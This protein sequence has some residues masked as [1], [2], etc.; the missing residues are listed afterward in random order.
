MASGADLPVP[1]E[2]SPQ[3]LYD[4]APCGYLTAL[5]DGTVV[6]VNQTFLQW[7]GY[8]R[9]DL[10]G[11]RRFRDLLAVGSLIYYE[12]HVGP[13]L[14]M[15]NE[16]REIALDVTCADGRRLPMLFNAMVS[17]D[18][19]GAPRLIRMT[20]FDATERRRYE[21]ELLRSRQA[22][23]E[24]ER[25]VRVLQKVVAELA[26]APTAT[27]VARTMVDVADAAFGTAQGAGGAPADATLWLVDA[28]RGRLL[29]AAATMSGE[30]GEMRLDA[31]DAPAA[32]ARSGEPYASPSVDRLRADFP[33]SAQ[34][35]VRRGR[36]SS[37][38]LPLVA[39]DV[40]LGVLACAFTEPREFTEDEVQL[41]RMLGQQ[42]GQALDRA[43]LYDEA[44]RREERAVFL[45]ETTR[46]LD[47]THEL[48]PRARR[49]VERLVPEIASWAAVRLAGVPENLAELGAP[50]VGADTVLPLTVRGK[51]SG[52][53]VLRLP[54]DGPPPEF[55]A[56]LAA[57]AALALENARLYEQEHA[58]ARTLQR[59]L[60]AGE[61]PSDLRFAVDT[62]Y[63][64]ST[65][66]LEVGGDWYDAFLIT[67]DK[68]AVV[69]GD[70][71]GRGIHAASTMGQ[72]R[73]AIRALAAAE[74]GPARLVEQLDRFVDQF[75]QARMATVAYAEI[76]LST[77][78]MVYCCAGHMP[79]LLLPRVG[80]PELLWGGRSAPLG[81]RAGRT[82]RSDA[83]VRLPEGVRLL[84]YTDGL[85]ERRDRP[86]D[87]GFA[88]LAAIF[89]DHRD[90]PLTGLTGRLADAM[91]DH[92]QPD[93]V[94]LL[95]VSIGVERHL[96]RSIA[97]DPR[98]IAAV[99]QDLRGWLTA[100]AIDEEARYAV[101]LAC[102]E[103]VTNAIEHG[104]RRHPEGVVEVRATLEDASVLLCVRDTGSWRERRPEPLRGRG[105]QLMRE[106]MDEVDVD[107]SGGTTVT[108]RRRVSPR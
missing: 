4:Q 5:P 11:R 77:G 89:G 98:R 24:S 73:S 15:Q 69:V 44:R 106:V 10:A 29:L 78:E 22:A 55:F 20:V 3:D 91:V 94:C 30:P 107:C 67:A 25:R 65:Q 105:L 49:L 47:E 104:Y 33:A 64:P 66:G 99:R 46:A 41:A 108:M 59:S 70:V 32:V 56:E 88:Q 43:R 6:N 72:L 37:L 61:P 71:V 51:V 58:V 54:P 17:R 81:S 45:A 8:G 7:T 34:V 57:S 1:W 19:D 12:T 84:L 21:Q 75:E 36:Q 39:H 103:A 74:A 2:E 18:D 95:C 26:A 102:S 50:G 42:A 60:L 93:D 76:T 9:T 90:G 101:L 31:P 87:V 28:D 83:T 96:A 68:L 35:L 85:V 100:H 97:A 23:E 79:P 63:R 13:L 27:A 52:T 38:L 53:L 48:R 80:E 14:G 40:V 86:L 62:H 92:D 16:V 82:V